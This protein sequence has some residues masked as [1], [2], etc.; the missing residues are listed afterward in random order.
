VVV[1]QRFHLPRAV[2]LARRAGIDAVGLEADRHVYRKWL[3]NEVRESV[4]RVKSVGEMHLDIAPRFLGPEIPIEG[5][6]RAT[7]DA[8]SGGGAA[9]GPAGRGKPFYG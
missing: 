5:D 7:Q 9:G 1:T 2:Y 3:L 8:A 6:G 4:A